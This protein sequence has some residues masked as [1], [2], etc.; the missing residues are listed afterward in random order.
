MSASDTPSR[1]KEQE[2]LLKT[3]LCRAFLRE[4]FQQ[5]SNEIE[6]ACGLPG[7]PPPLNH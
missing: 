6:Q 5:K 3:S 1:A 2:S 7:N 4:K